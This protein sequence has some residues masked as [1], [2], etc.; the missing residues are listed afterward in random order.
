[1]PVD[2]TSTQNNN[3]KINEYWLFGCRGTSIL[4]SLMHQPNYKVPT[5]YAD[6]FPRLARSFFVS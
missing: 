3:Q 1:M 6:F 4:A 2:F 5:L